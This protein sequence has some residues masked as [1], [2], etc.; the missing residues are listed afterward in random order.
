MPTSARILILAQTDPT[1]SKKYT[2][3]VCTAGIEK[4]PD[5][6]S[7]GGC[8][9]RWIRLYPIMK[10]ALSKDKKYSKYQWI[11]CA[12]EE[13]GQADDKRPESRK[14]FMDKIFPQEEVTTGKNRLWE[15]RKDILLHSGLAVYESK[16]EILE[17][18]K[19]NEFSLCL[20][21]PAKILSFKAYQ[22]D[23]NFTQEERSI[24]ERE[25]NQEYFP[26]LYPGFSFKDVKF[27]KLPYFFKC[28]FRD[29]EGKKS[30]LSVLDWEMS[31]LLR[32]EIKNI[33][34]EEEAK[35][36]TLKK[37]NGFIRKNDVYFILGTRNKD[38]NKFMKN[39]DSGINPWSIISI[40]PFPKGDCNMFFN[41]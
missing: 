20:F 5:G 33:K 13:S 23:K 32:R 25:R 17:A 27:E 6:L 11:E 41:F 8:P 29:K 30:E 38:H 39:P 24:I 15:E 34:N 21:K 10:R 4:L 40:I 36:S 7:S 16:D 19:R 22:Q 14:V 35:E 9:Y 1:F 12:I 3:T 28:E 26:E 2:E 37:Y 31:S 18:V